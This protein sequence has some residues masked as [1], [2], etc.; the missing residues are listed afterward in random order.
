MD[1]NIENHKLDFIVK[2]KTSTQIGK[3]NELIT[4]FAKVKLHIEC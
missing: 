4:I 2:F 3:S 1:V